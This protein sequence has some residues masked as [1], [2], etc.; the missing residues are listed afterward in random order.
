VNL[1][2]RFGGFVRGMRRCDIGS[3]QS[4]GER[5]GSIKSIFAAG[6]VPVQRITEVRVLDPYSDK[7]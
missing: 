1:D 5:V 7:E 2:D 3:V 6:N 4:N